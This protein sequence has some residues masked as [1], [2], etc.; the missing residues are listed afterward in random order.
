[1]NQKFLIKAMAL[2]FVP[3]VMMLCANYDYMVAQDFGLK[4]S[5]PVLLSG[6][7]TIWFVV[8]C[9]LVFIL[10]GMKDEKTF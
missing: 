3:V 8:L 6:V 1:M 2:V 10:G 4:L 7:C 9:V 5:L